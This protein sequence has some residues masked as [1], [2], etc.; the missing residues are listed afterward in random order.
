MSSAGRPAALKHRLVQPRRSSGSQT[1]LAT[2]EPAVD[3]QRRRGRR[4]RP[5][6]RFRDLGRSRKLPGNGRSGHRWLVGDRRTGN[7]RRDRRRRAR[8]SRASTSRPFRLVGSAPGQFLSQP[9]RLLSSA[10]GLRLSRL[11]RLLGSAPGLRRSRLPRLLGSAPG[12]FLSRLPRLLGSALCARLCFCSVD[13]VPLDEAL[14]ILGDA[15][16]LAYGRPMPHLCGHASECDR[17]GRAAQKRPPGIASV[18]GRTARASRPPPRGS[19]LR[20]S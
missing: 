11:P 17:E 3:R 5:L 8:R 16:G 9:A 14:T 10:P 15:R 7:R 19:A 2:V 12:L 20:A 6:P 13:H 4:L 1:R 18:S